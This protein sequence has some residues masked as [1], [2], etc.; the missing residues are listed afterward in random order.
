MNYDNSETQ[1][2][3]NLVKVKITGTINYNHWTITLNNIVPKYNPLS[4]GR[5]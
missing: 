4:I 2:I 1:V 3:L 5:M